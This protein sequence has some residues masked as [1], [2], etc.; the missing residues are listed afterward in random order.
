MNRNEIAQILDK[1]GWDCVCESPIEFEHRQD[2][3][4]ICNWTLAE[5]IAI[6]EQKGQ[7]V[8]YVLGFRFSTDLKKVVLIEKLKPS[9]QAGKLNGVGGKL[10]SNETLS[11]AIAREFKEETSVQT[12]P[13]EW[14]YALTMIDKKN[15]PKNWLVHV[16]CSV[17]D[18][19]Q[20]HTVE[21]EKIFICDV[22]NL[23]KNLI[24]NL[25]WQIPMLL[26]QTVQRP[27]EIGF[28]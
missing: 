9:W 4:K 10:E 18:I 15:E 22:D 2:G 20:C 11:E 24:P 25:R 7:M 26:D 14:S 6:E 1:S 17:G 19:T 12:Y 8:E 27:I 23:P 16:F 28:I 13:S 3:S 5:L 21:R